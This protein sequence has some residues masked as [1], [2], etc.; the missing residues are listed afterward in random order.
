MP[1]NSCGQTIAP[2]YVV[3]PFGR[4]DAQER[5]TTDKAGSKG[6]T[7]TIQFRHTDIPAQLYRSAG[8]NRRRRQCKSALQ[9]PWTLAP[10]GAQARH[11]LRPGIQPGSRRSVPESGQIHSGG[12]SRPSGGQ[13]CEGR[14]LE[15][16]CSRRPCAISCPSMRRITRAAGSSIRSGTICYRF[17]NDAAR[18]GR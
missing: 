2:Y 16:G 6:T 4:F 17:R 9:A 10:A 3:P 12:T 11:G 18:N 5:S 1:G 15:I 14:R 7:P 13:A 8:R